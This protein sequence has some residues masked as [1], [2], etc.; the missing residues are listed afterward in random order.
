VTGQHLEDADRLAHTVTVPDA[1]RGGWPWP[2]PEELTMDPRRQQIAR[3]HFATLAALFNLGTFRRIE[4]LGIGPGWRCWEVGAGGA[5]VP[6]WLAQR[7]SPGGWVLA[8]DRDVAALEAAVQEDAGLHD[9]AGAGDGAFEIRRHELG[10]DP[11]PHGGFDL[12]HARL[13]LMHVPD[14]DGALATMITALRPGGWLLVEDADP[15]L[16]PLACPDEHGPAAKRANK[17]RV[18]TWEVMSRR[19][20]LAFGRTLPRLLG[21]A[22]LA[23]VGADA[24]ISLAGPAQAQFQRT[25]IERQ[26][27]R[28]VGAGLAT[29]AE[30]EQHLADIEAGRVD[31]ASFPVVSA[32]GRKPE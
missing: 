23:E 13:V 28:L 12:V 10:A 3:T 4:M 26:R 2:V 19:T 15:L 22:G 25:I 24:Y 6:R 30:I 32:W 14:R 20:D 27:D 1:G 8:T 31:M 16:H 11:A 29:D 9:A 18:A 17:L 7:S 21:S 5:T